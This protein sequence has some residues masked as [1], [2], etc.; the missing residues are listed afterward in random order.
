MD[1]IKLT[2]ARVRNDIAGYKQR[3]ER[4]RQQIDDLEGRMLPRREIPTRRRR[5]ALKNEV[6]HVKQLI[7]YAQDLL[8][9]LEGGTWFQF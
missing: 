3:I 7:T 1:T 5:Q 9:L 8:D 6:A 2:T 4:V